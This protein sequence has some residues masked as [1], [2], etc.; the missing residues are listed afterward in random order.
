MR[1]LP[2]LLLTQGTGSG[3]STSKNLNVIL[4][5]LIGYLSFIKASYDCCSQNS[6]ISWIQSKHS[7]IFWINEYANT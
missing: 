2:M 3:Y 4:E 7:N 5:C 1:G 6:I